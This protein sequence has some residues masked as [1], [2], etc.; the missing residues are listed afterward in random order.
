[1]PF[2]TSSTFSVPSLVI[3]SLAELPVSFNKAREGP[4]G[5]VVSSVNVSIE[6]AGPMFPAM[7]V[8]RAITL[9]APSTGAKLAIHAV[10]PSMEYCTFAPVSTL[11]SGT[12][13]SLVMRSVTER[14]MSFASAMLG[15]P[16]DDVSRTK[17][18]GVDAARA[19]PATPISPTDTELAPSTG[20]KF[21]A[22]LAPP[23]TE[24]WPTATVS[25]PLNVNAPLLVIESIPELPVSLV[26]AIA[27][28]TG[29]V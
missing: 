16:G 2:S 6:D 28:A 8:W 18:N 26:N 29:A 11:L 17:V 14:P 5:R 1:A 19:L 15:A 27:G 4:A 3:E 10:P 20:T 7:S 24:N 25:T 22:Q 21:A 12:V 13:P 9:F 23:S